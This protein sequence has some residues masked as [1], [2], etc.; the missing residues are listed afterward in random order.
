MGE[1][2]LKK[3]LEAGITTFVCL[4]VRLEQELGAACSCFYAVLHQHCLEQTCWTKCWAWGGYPGLFCTPAA[5]AP[6]D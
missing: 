6:A 5:E 4:Q 3:I 2:Q 1:A